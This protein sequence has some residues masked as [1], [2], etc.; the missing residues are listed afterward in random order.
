MHSREDCVKI[1]LC[2]LIRV[3]LFFYFIYFLSLLHITVVSIQRVSVIVMKSRENFLYFFN[4]KN[5]ILLF[6]TNFGDSIYEQLNFPYFY[7]FF[8]VV[9]RG[10]TMIFMCLLLIAFILSEV[11]KRDVHETHACCHMSQNS[12]SIPTTSRC[13]NDKNKI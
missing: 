1:W 13:I 4:I 5:E 11:K 3:S 2:W 8:V 7:N 12:G 10:W 6:G 9:S